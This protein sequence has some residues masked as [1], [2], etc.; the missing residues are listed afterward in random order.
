[1][2]DNPDSVTISADGVPVVVGEAALGHLGPTTIAVAMPGGALGWAA[3][4]GTDAAPAEPDIL[5]TPSGPMR[6]PKP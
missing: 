3:A 5:I 1:M 6:R 4:A 2:A